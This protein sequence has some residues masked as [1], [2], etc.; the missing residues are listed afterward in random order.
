MKKVLI[1]IT[2]DF[3]PWGGLTTVAMNYYRAMDKTDLQI[4]FVSDNET[5]QSLL[6]E[7]GQN[8][9]SYIRLP[10]RKKHTFKYMAALH[11]QLKQGEY[12]TIHIHGNS[13]TMLIDMLPAWLLKVKKRIVH[14]HNSTGNHLILHQIL[15]PILCC[16]CT[17]LIAC[18]TKAGRWAFGKR[19]FQVLNNA[20]DTE[21]FFYN[22]ETRNNIR[23]KLNIKSDC[24]VIGHTGKINRQKNHEY[25]IEIFN[26]FH[27]GHPDS[28]LLLVGDGILRKNIEEK[29]RLYGIENSVIFCGMVSNAND[30]LSVM[31]CFVFPSLWEGFPLSLIE[32]QA[33]GLKCIVSDVITKE[34]NVSGNVTYLRVETSTELWV[35]KIVESVNYDR[36]ANAAIARKMKHGNMEIR[37]QAGRLREIYVD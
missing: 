12:D 23:K 20:I 7:L 35:S 22:F 17:D 13:A 8:G 19:N 4:D 10:D 3:V 21:K 36:E 6:D 28:M 26:E 27:K 14:T 18:S 11:R 34:T 29:I 1:V 15:R 37:E 31:D 24:F 32:A 30:Y 25:L 2:T 16:L 9:S 5:E 33:N